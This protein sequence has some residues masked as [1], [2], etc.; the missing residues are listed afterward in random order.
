MVDVMDQETYRR[1]KKDFT[2]WSRTHAH[3]MLVSFP[4]S[5]RNYFGALLRRASGKIVVNGIPEV[6]SHP[7]EDLFIFICHRGRWDIVGEHGKYILLVRDPRDAILSRTYQRSTES[8]ID[9]QNLLQDNGWLYEQNVYEWIRYF[10]I[11]KPHNPLIIQ[12]ERLCLDPGKV[13]MQTLDFL[14]VKPVENTDAVVENYD[15]IKP[16][17][18][19]YEEMERTSFASGQDRY[20]RHCLKWQRDDYMTQPVLD[21]TWRILGPLMFD[22]GYTETGHADTLLSGSNE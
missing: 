3:N 21:A 17:P 18:H 8:G 9:V 11:L 15:L 1:F 14:D 5:G 10:D 12:Y 19:R 13:V 22:Y 6:D 4:K 7:Y 2:E 16:D 20:D